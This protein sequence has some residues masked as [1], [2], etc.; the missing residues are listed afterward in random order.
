[1]DHGSA[2]APAAEKRRFQFS[3]RALFLLAFGVALAFSAISSEGT[4]W[5]YGLFAPLIVFIVIGLI[6][7]VRDLWRT[8]NARPDLSSEERWGWR[9]AVFWRVGVACLLVGHY[10]ITAL[11][12][13]EVLPLPE[14]EDG[15]WEVGVNL[16]HALLHLSLLVVLASVPSPTEKRR[17][18]AQS[19]LLNVT[20]AI[21]ALVWCFVIWTQ[22]TVVAHLVH[23]ALQG[24]E[25]TWPPQFADEGLDA[26]MTGRS[27]A[28][29]WR[30]LFSAALVFVDLVLLHQLSR[31][32]SR[33]VRRRLV[34]AGFLALSLA[35]TAWYPVWVYTSGLRNMSPLMAEAMVMGPLHLWVSALL[36][37]I[38]FVSAATYRMV[39][40]PEMPSHTAEKSWRRNPLRY[41]HE[42]P[43]VIVLLATAVILFDLVSSW[44]Q[45]REWRYYSGMFP[46]LRSYVSFV[47]WFLQ[48]F[49][50]DPVRYMSL[51]V[52]LLAL[53]KAWT[54]WPQRPDSPP[55]GPPVLPL[56]RF[57]AIWIAMFLTAVTGIPTIAWFSFA[58]WMGP[59]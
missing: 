33:G 43:G 56:P 36:L 10:I 19:H 46:G 21:L 48:S 20:G 15:F 22:Q 44:L 39:Q 57:S 34:L 49:L 31:Q 6:S 47:W 54:G 17:R 59:W 14:R 23:V 50:Y 11:E 9:F 18:S 51:A 5:A 8:F 58:F 16:R 28:F 4:N 30:S 55:A 12:A 3:L 27:L 7:Q 25:A 29:F 26:D 1:M 2:D 38:V 41:Y 32:W 40:T 42:R 52:L 37:M 24:I 35:M 45:L 13:Q 53:Q